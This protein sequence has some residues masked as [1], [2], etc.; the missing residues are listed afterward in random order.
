MDLF[1]PQ[2]GRQH[3]GPFFLINWNSEFCCIF[4]HTKNNQ[5]RSDPWLTPRQVNEAIPV[6]ST[7][8]GDLASKEAAAA[9][10]HL[11]WAQTSVPA[12]VT[13]KLLSES[14]FSANSCKYTSNTLKKHILV[15]QVY[16]NKLISKTG[17]HKN[18]NCT[19]THKYMLPE[20]KNCCALIYP[21]L[22]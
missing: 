3:F 9:E 10:F 18:Q 7:G 13:L 17:L 8:K 22:C 14:V 21:I 1:C 15:P 16:L 6:S 11:Q 4:Y 20:K 5:R 19:Q 12:T 2:S